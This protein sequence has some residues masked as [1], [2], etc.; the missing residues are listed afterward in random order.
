MVLRR[1]PLWL[2]EPHTCPY[3]ADRTARLGWVSPDTPMTA[4]V[5]MALV[6]AGFRRS[7]RNVYRPYC[8]GCMCCIPIRVP[9]AD[10]SPDRVQR[11]TWRRNADLRVSIVAADF[12]AEHYAL[13]LRYQ[14]AR[15]S[16]E[17]MASAS[18]EEYMDFLVC[19]WMETWFVEFR[20]G[21][22]LVALAV[23]D[24]LD[25]GLSAVYSFFDP[26]D[27]KSSLGT[28]AIL[29]LIAM[30]KRL[31]LPWCYLGYWVSGSPKMHYKHRFRP[32]EARIGNQWIRIERR[33]P[34]KLADRDV[35]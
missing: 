25:D 23:V 19:S 32:L 28:Y 8:P 15:H 18:P 3:L 16:G 30:T 21:T 26:E 2:G 13:Y 10:F 9:A 7:G 22:E 5:Y 31:G 17:A 27:S 6:R 1:I 14:R 20:R 35:L 11:R 33:Q 29:Q 12:D 4:S 34:I 24:H